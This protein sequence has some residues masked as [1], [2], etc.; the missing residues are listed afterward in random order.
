MW[1]TWGDLG[2]NGSEVD[3]GRMRG[4]VLCNAAHPTPPPMSLATPSALV[5]SSGC[6]F[7]GRFAFGPLPQAKQIAKCFNG[8]FFGRARPSGG[9]CRNSSS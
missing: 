8:S 6:A 9:V 4:R 5:A 1:L 3:P 2:S 7:R